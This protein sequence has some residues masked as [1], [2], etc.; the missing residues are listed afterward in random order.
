[1]KINSDYIINNQKTYELFIYIS[2]SLFFTNTNKFFR[3]KRVE[4]QYF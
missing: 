4:Q 3:K 1:M 2:E